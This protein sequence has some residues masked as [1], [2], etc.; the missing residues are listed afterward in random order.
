MAHFTLA[1]C[2]GVALLGCASVEQN[3]K[4]SL[5]EAAGFKVVAANTPEKIRL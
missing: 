4:D 1:L 3:R 2:F 5:L